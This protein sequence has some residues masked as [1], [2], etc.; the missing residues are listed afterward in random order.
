MKQNNKKDCTL[1]YTIVFLIHMSVAYWVPTLTV[2]GDEMGPAA[3]AA[4]LAGEDWSFVVQKMHLPYYGYGQAILYVPIFLITKAP[5]IRYLLMGTVNS[6]LLAAIPIFAYQILGRIQ[7]LSSKKRFWFALTVSLFPPYLVFTKWIWNETLLCVLP[8]MLLFLIIRCVE[9]KGNIVVE[10][11]ALAFTTVYCYAVHG[12]GILY[13]GVVVLT[14]IYLYARYKIKIVNPLSFAVGFVGSYWIHNAVKNFLTV[15]L[16]KHNLGEALMGTIS[17]TVPNVFKLFSTEGITQFLTMAA[18]H[19]MSAVL[20]SYGLLVLVV[21]F[22]IH[23][24]AKGFRTYPSYPQ[25][26]RM[27]LHVIGVFAILCFAGAI[28]I[29][30]IFLL[31]LV[32]DYL[33]YTRYYAGTMGFIVL[34]AILILQDKRFLEKYWKNVLIAFLCCVPLYFVILSDVEIGREPV[35]MNLY[36]YL[37]SDEDPVALLWASYIIFGIFMLFL[38]VTKSKYS[39][40]NIIILLGVFLEAYYFCGVSYIIPE[41]VGKEQT[42]QGY[43]GAPLQILQEIAD[44]PQHYR[45]IAFYDLSWKFDMFNLQYTLPEYQTEMVRRTEEIKQTVT[46]NIFIVSRSNMHFDYMYRDIYRIND[47]RLESAGNYMWVYG[48]DLNEYIENHGSCQTVN[49]YGEPYDLKESMYTREGNE[50]LFLLYGPYIPLASGTYTITIGGTLESGDLNSDSYFDVVHNKSSSWITTTRDLSQFVTGREFELSVDFELE[51]DVDDCE[52][53]VNV[54]EG[55]ELNI[56]SIN[57]R[58]GIN[59]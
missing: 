56:N 29:D 6:A 26:D 13:I 24:K 55:V 25:E 22:L 47:A 59:P 41:S 21:F 42:I 8:W 1:L 36:P 52:F 18:G 39:R 16:W 23:P 12:R 15:N 30:L 40:F 46:E 14:I 53:R 20:S 27:T 50:G 54:N 17:G 32:G 43:A 57:I 34:W 5:E 11:V 33:I 31:G 35:F 4:Y 28:F 19:L 7:S 38:A 45:R 48:E 2:L 44:L 58:K 49:H 9:K 3:I 10:S 51:N 37:V